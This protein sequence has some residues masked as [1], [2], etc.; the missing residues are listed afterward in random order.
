MKRILFAL[1]SLLPLIAFSQTA[2]PIQW[3]NTIGSNGYDVIHAAQQTSDGGYI[4]AGHSTSNSSAD[5]SENNLGFEDCWI[6]KLDVNGNIEWENT[7][8]GSGAEFAM[9]VKQTSDGGYIIGAYSNSN[10]SADKSENQK[11]ST[12][13]WI[14]K[15]NSTGAI[16]WENTIG[17]NSNDELCSIE[18]TD[19]GGYLAAGWSQS[20]ISSDKTEASMGA[21]DYWIVK[22]NS[23]GSIV[24][25]NTIG[26]SAG[27]QLKS[28]AKTSDG[29]FLLGGQSNSGIS[30][31]KTEAN[32]FSNDLWVVKV[33]DLGNIVWQ[34]TITSGAEDYFESIQE[35]TDG[36]AILGAW[37]NSN[38]S[39]DKSEN[40]Q[41]VWDYWVLKLDPVGN[42]IWQNTIGGTQGDYLYDIKQTSDGGYLCGG[43]S[44]SGISGDKTD[45]T[46]GGLDYWIVKLD[47]SGSILWQNS[48]G[49]SNL[50]LF[51]DIV[52][53]DDNGYLLLGDSHSGIGGDKTEGN[54]GLTDFWVVKTAPECF[55]PTIS[56]V[57]VNDNE[58]CIGDSI[59]LTITGDLQS[60]EYWAIYSGS[61]GGTLVDTTSQ[62]SIW[63][64]PTTNTDYFVRGEGGC[65]TPGTCSSVSVTVN[66]LP[67]V[68]AGIDS[69]LCVGATYTLNASG[70]NLYS[71]NNGVGAVNPAV[72]SPTSNLHYTVTGTDVNG[73]INIDSVLVSVNNLPIVNAGTDTTLCIAATYTLHASGANTY[74]WNHGIGALNPANVSPTDTLQYTVIGTDINGCTNTDSVIVNVNV[75][76][77]VFAG[78]DTLICN[79]VDIVLTASGANTYEWIDV[80]IG[81]PVNTDPLT[82]DST[83]I[84][85]GTDLNGCSNSDTMEVTIS[86]V[87]T[88][89][90][91]I[92]QDTICTSHSSI[93]L[94]ATPS[95]GVFTG[96]GVTGN[97]FD[98]ATAPTPSPIITHTFTPG[99]GSTD[100]EF[101]VIMVSPC[102]G[103]GENEQNNIF[104]FPNPASDYLNISSSTSTITSIEIVDLTGRKIKT[105]NL[106]TNSGMIDINE[107]TN[108]AYLLNMITE[109]GTTTKRFIKH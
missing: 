54:Y 86:V 61:C 1:I 28:M 44:D 88:I 42:I 63:V 13:F 45:N 57:T 46:N 56:N 79:N 104:L 41:G 50:E 3:Q 49:G 100:D 83:F 58:V 102:L 38:I 4:I 99:H 90:F 75:L 66:D 80:A 93:S 21:L 103:I 64:H 108:G 20:G 68:N 106:N 70:A 48:L 72:V 15:L 9:D 92:G 40:S 73:C 101:D 78:N 60:A 5:K 30:G 14:I 55:N 22:L 76:P 109:N 62:N 19:D 94:S 67:T 32:L 74:L 91:T 11:G 35:T 96:N 51:Y 24:W 85:L 18:I 65:V 69:T 25:Q 59:Q 31:D 107:L 2:P 16:V 37:S 12:D 77:N 87:P 10:A 34:N 97:T 33:D 7:I 6:V 47:A 29:G 98:P 17:G 27:D 8:G 71:W 36:G 23:T 81:N 26:G 82:T 84:V 53:T 52:I 95:G 89:N 43:F 39:G 105:I